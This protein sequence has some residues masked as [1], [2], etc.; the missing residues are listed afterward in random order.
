M[1]IA[2]TFKQQAKTFLTGIQNRRR[3][4]ARRATIR[5]YQSYLSRWILPLLG[6]KDLSAIDNGILKEFTVELSKSLK[7]ATITAILAVTKSVIAS[8]V[9]GN[10]N[11]LY[12]RK[13]NNDFIDAPVVKPADQDAPTVPA[14]AI[15]TAIGR[16]KGTDK[17][18]YALLAGS[19]LRVGEALGLMVGP[20]DGRNSFWQPETAILT[21]R[22]TVVEGEIQE[23]PK[24]E[25]GIREVDLAPELNSFLCQRLLDGELPGTG[26]LFQS[27]TKGPVRLGT[28][29]KH[30]RAAGISE[31]FHAFRRFR[32][33]HLEAM[34]VPRGLA[35]WWTGH[36]PGSVHES[37]I[38]MGK[39]L[40]VRKEWA[41][42]VGLGF[43]LEAQ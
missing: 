25:A 28:A 5:S 30:L 19:G 16:A 14:V 1:E 2:M 43:Q 7:P 42:K 37:Y 34:N 32:C 20:D 35:M 21:I 15:E 3:N 17:A 33:T 9:D 22:T 29:Y 6:E 41:A 23:A 12:P 11:E 13:W 40:E 36:A 8:A 4:P 10:G 24:T 26:L 38:K 27:Q 39:N 31:G 18:L